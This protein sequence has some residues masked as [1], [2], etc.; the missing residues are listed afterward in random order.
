MPGISSKD[1]AGWDSGRHAEIFAPHPV[2]NLG[3]G[4]GGDVVHNSDRPHPAK[5]CGRLWTGV[6]A[7]V[8]DPVRP[9]R[10]AP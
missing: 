8:L 9:V 4:E 1:T 3:N 6:D 7:P 5:G 2:G 10:A